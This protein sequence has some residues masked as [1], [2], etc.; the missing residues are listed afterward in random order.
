MN[1]VVDA[2]L[3]KSIS[4]FLNNIGH[5]SVHTLQLIARN[6]TTDETIIELA[7]AEKRIVITKDYDFLVSHLV[8]SRP[9]KL[10]L[11]KTGNINNSRLI[12]LFEKYI[13]NMVKYLQENRLIEM[14]IDELVVQ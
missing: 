2:Q 10:I 1:F 13:E 6:K 9:S 12:G 7:E 3:P 8:L 14:Y 5:N 4:D 11:V